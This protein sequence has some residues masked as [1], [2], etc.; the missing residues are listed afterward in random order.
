LRVRRW[1]RKALDDSRVGGDVMSVVPDG[2]FA[3]SFPDESA[4]YFLLVIDRGTMPV[5]R[6]GKDRT[7]MARKLATY[8]DGW[9]AGRH[10]EQFGVKQ[11]RVLTVTSSKKRH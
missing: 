5:V 8:W 10:V 1:I 9:K 11:L 3:L 6:R 7:S 2:L 4:S